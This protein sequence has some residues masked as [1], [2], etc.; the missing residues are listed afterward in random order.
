MSGALVL[1]PT[2]R[3]RWRETSAAPDGG[4]R[5]R[6]VLEQLWVDGGRTRGEWLPVERVPAESGSL[7][8]PDEL[9]GHV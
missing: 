4:R 8:N 3:M 2:T 1:R 5:Q 7:A 9:R 6:Y